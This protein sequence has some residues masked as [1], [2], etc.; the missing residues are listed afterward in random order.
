L[1]TLQRGVVWEEVLILLPE[2][3][4]IVML[5]ATI[6][7]YIEFAEWVGKIKQRNIYVMCTK[8]RPVPLEHYLYTGNSSKTC[9]ERFLIYAS[10]SDGKFNTINYGKA[11]EAKKNRAKNSSAPYGPKGTKQSVTPAQVRAIMIN[12]LFLEAK[13]HLVE[14]KKYL[15]LTVQRIALDQ[16]TASCCVFIFA[17][18]L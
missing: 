5:S 9:K 18:T 11:I 1:K 8:K 3:I 6:P 10:N 13:L 14:G 7:N 17:Q 4:N 16:P 2:H 12:H 15:S